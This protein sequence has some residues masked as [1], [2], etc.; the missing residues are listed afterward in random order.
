MNSN[1]YSSG[2]VV[3][4]ND[5]LLPWW[6]PSVGYLM[7]GTAVALTRIVDD[8]GNPIVDDTGRVIGFNP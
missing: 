2:A 5:I 1:K 6:W 8:A 7:G 4:K 3:L